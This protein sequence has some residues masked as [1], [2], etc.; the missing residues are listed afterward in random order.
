MRSASK[1]DA[2]SEVQVA[3]QWKPVKKTLPE[4]DRLTIGIVGFGLFGQFIG[5][6]MALAGHRVLATSRADYSKEAAPLRILG[7]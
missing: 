7:K 2:E 4:E 1:A 3:V 5:R 6:R